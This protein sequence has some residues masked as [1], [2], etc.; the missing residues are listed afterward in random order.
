M[1]KN[2]IDELLKE[3]DGRIIYI[4]Q[5]LQLLC[6][7]GYS[8]QESNIIRKAYAKKQLDKVIEFEKQLENSLGN[9]IANYLISKIRLDCGSVYWKIHE[10][11]YKMCYGLN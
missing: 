2:S 3:T 5:L 11:A 10:N 4:E 1:S 6:N 7:A 9:D 8:L